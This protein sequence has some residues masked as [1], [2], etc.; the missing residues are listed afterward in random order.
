M[1]TM[2]TI[3][4]ALSAGCYSAF[5]GAAAGLIIGVFLYVVIYVVT[6][7]MAYRVFFLSPAVGCGLVG[8]WGLLNACLDPDTADMLVPRVDLHRDPLR[9]MGA[10]AG[11]VGA[12]MLGAY[13]GY[14]QAPAEF[15]VQLKLALGWGAGTATLGGVVGAA[16]GVVLGGVWGTIRESVGLSDPVDAPFPAEPADKGKP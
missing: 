1:S 14:I 7:R 2:R 3:R 13:Y 5:V 16:L 10:V 12:G 6:G 8:L 9:Q 15:A 4:N 11:A